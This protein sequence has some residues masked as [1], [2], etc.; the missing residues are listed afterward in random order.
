MGNFGNNDKGNHSDYF[1]NNIKTIN[2]NHINV[3]NNDNGNAEKLTMTMMEIIM[4]IFSLQ[5]AFQIMS[6]S[7][8]TV[9]MKIEQWESLPNPLTTSCNLEHSE[10]SVCNN[11]TR[12][13]TNTL[14]N[15]KMVR[16]RGKM[17]RNSQ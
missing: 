8:I 9:I 7:S 5:R 10:S 12:N 2:T 13:F 4:V 14:H 6:M 11:N 1:H 3:L 16:S 15:Q 17:H